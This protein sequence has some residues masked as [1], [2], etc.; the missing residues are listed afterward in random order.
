MVYIEFSDVKRMKRWWMVIE[1]GAVDLCLEDPGH[2]IDVA[3]YAD[4]LTLTQIYIGDLTINRARSLGKI[5]VIG[6]D[7]LVRIM[8]RWFARSKFA[9]V[10][11]LPV[12][13]SRAQRAQ[14][15]NPANTP[16]RTP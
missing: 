3:I 11:P 8:P 16:R 12:E 2:E 1:N 9:D 13:E 15:R 10:N 4:L 7:E 6:P 14:V 5:K